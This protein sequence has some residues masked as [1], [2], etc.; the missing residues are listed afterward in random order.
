M[1]ELVEIETKDHM[2]TV[3]EELIRDMEQEVNDKL[4]KTVEDLNI[5][6]Y[7]AQEVTGQANI[8]RRS[9]VWNEPVYSKRKLA[10]SKLTLPS[11]NNEYE[12]PPVAE[13]NQTPLLI[14]VSPGSQLFGDPR[15]MYPMCSIPRGYA[16]II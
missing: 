7:D 1:G 3:G 15:R 14:D 4:S 11:S 6:C 2:D 13:D 8:Q 5:D 10:P 16:L 12:P 9:K